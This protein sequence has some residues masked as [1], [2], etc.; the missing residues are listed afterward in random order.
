MSFI[1]DLVPEFKVGHMLPQN[2]ALLAFKAAAPTISKESTE[3]GFEL[4]G[5]DFMIDADLNVFLIEVNQNPCLATL[6]ERQKVLIS[7]L[8]A[9][10]LSLTVDPMF[11]LEPSDAGARFQLHLSPK[12]QEDPEVYKTRYE[13]I[14][15]HSEDVI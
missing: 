7:N 10:T 9:D 4:L 12:H 6:C 1:K 15:V 2:K 3:I 14:H 11:G 8:V 13:L 5:F